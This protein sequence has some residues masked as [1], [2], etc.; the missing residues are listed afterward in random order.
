MQAKISEFETYLLDEIAKREKLAKKL[1]FQ[2][3]YQTLLGMALPMALGITY[4]H[5]FIWHKHIAAPGTYCFLKIKPII[6]CK[7]TK[8]QFN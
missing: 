3:L 7:A 6:C 4:K 2:L 1:N 8:T 5:G